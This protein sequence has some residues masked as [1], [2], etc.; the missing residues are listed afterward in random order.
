MGPGPGLLLAWGYLAQC[1]ILRGVLVPPTATRVPAKP[2]GACL[3]QAPRVAVVFHDLTTLV[4]RA[5]IQALASGGSS[6]GCS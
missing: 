3:E 4:D 6:L 1:P 2:M 5:G